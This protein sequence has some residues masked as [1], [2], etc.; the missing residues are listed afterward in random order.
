MGCL[1]GVAFDLDALLLVLA[2]EVIEKRLRVLS[3]KL[4]DLLR[5][6]VFGSSEGIFPLRTA[7]TYPVEGSGSLEMNLALR[8]YD[9]EVPQQASVKNDPSFET[10]ATIRQL[11]PKLVFLFPSEVSKMLWIPSCLQMLD[12]TRASGQF[13][14]RQRKRDNRVKFEGHVLIPKLLVLGL[15]A[16]RH[17]AAKDRSPNKSPPRYWIKIFQE[18]QEASYSL[19]WELPNFA[20]IRV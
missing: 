8:I 4:N 17:Q 18:T 12:E 6:F 19:A 11:G 2:R 7:K 16:V 5:D 13:G 14:P 10:P 15:I 20:K 3:L 9:F 1:E